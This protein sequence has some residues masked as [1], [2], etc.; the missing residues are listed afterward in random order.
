MDVMSTIHA[1]IEECSDQNGILTC[2]DYEGR[3]ITERI[4]N[5]LYAHKVMKKVKEYSVNNTTVYEDSRN[6]AGVLSIAYIDEKDHLELL[7]YMWER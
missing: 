6:E 1:V 3:N 2:F 4:S 7:S 5:L